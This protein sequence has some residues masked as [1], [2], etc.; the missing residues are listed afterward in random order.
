MFTMN[1]PPPSRSRD[2]FVDRLLVWDSFLPYRFVCCHSAQHI[3]CE[4]VFCEVISQISARLEYLHFQ[5]TLFGRV[6]FFS[7]S[8][9]LRFAVPASL[10]VQSDPA[11]LQT[12]SRHLP[13]PILNSVVFLAMTLSMVI[14]LQKHVLIAT[15]CSKSHGSNAQAREGVLEPIPPAEEACVSPFL[16]IR[17]Q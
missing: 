16:A 10:Y 5:G 6:F 11:L 14:I 1:E 9:L 17:S 3:P 2:E 8:F 13:S 12:K 15:V 7:S 4:T